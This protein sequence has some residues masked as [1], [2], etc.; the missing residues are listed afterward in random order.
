VKWW[1]ENEGVGRARTEE[2]TLFIT[3]EA[4]EDGDGRLDQPVE[5]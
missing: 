2:S 5:S 1:R 4:G 3:G